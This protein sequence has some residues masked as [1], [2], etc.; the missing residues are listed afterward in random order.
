MIQSKRLCFKFRIRR[1]RII[2]IRFPST[3]VSMVC[4]LMVLSALT[5]PAFYK[6]MTST[7]YKTYVFTEI[8]PTSTTTV[9][10]PTIQGT[11]C[12]LGHLTFGPF[13][14]VTELTTYI[15]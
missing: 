1:L 14:V 7:G 5:W 13:T 11:Y 9:I 3:L 4:K 8:N 10:M 12:Q 6:T 2:E 15:D